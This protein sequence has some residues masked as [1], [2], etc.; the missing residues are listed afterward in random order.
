MVDGYYI[1]Q[2]NGAAGKP[3]GGIDPFESPIGENDDWYEHT[4]QLY[5]T[6]VVNDKVSMKA[7]IRLI[8]R[9]T[10]WGS[11]DDTATAD[12]GNMSIDKAW[13]LYDSPAGLI[14]VGRRPAGAWRGAFVNNATK[15]DRIMWWVPKMD[16]FKAYAFLQKSEEADGYVG[17]A[18]DAD[19]DY[20]EVA[21]GYEAEAMKFWLG[22]GYTRDQSQI[23]WV[24]SLGNFSVQ[25]VDDQDW[26]RLKGEADIAIN[27]TFG[28]LAE[29]DY[30]TGDKR[31]GATDVDG[32]AFMLS[33]TGKFDAL[34]AAL[35]YAYIS[36][37]DGNDEAYDS[38][39]GT[40]WDFEPLYILTGT[41]TN[42]LNGYRGPN[43]G[44]SLARTAGAHLLVG[45][46]DYAASEDLT[47]HGAVGWGQAD[48]A[49]GILD[50]S[51]GWE[52]NLGMAY[53]LYDNLT[54]ELHFGWWATGDFFELGG[55]T[56]TEDVMLLS[57]HLSM[58][59]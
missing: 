8:D 42:V 23:L 27:E 3:N 56:E 16:N 50:D 52:V 4:F 49:P 10:V 47:L 12:G 22:L 1:D 36:G 19:N 26:W 53:K 24:D 38:A 44:G 51:Y 59:F 17:W 15:A 5:P 41:A 28:M 20:Y 54:Y 29:F 13:L 46:A 2:G 32:F 30:K 6:L 48:E 43:F 33:G 57:H 14:E 25:D 11:Q 55:L 18:D 21:G 9:V 34:T 31:D 40:G 58:K 45:S 39:N 37:A 35:T 7:D